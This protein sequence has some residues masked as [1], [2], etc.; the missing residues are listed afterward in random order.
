MSMHDHPTSHSRAERLAFAGLDSGRRAALACQLPRLERAI[1]AA[2][3]RFY[4]HMASYPAIHAQL[5]GDG[6]IGRLKSLQAAHWRQLL[7]ARFDAA[8]FARAQAIG[9]AH[10]R[11]GL[12]PADYIAGY[13][14]VLADLAADL[15]AQLRWRPGRM[16]AAVSA[17]IEAALFDMALSLG[18][19]IEGGRAQ[20]EKELKALADQLE[21]QV[22]AGVHAV[23]EDSG[24]ARRDA[25]EMQKATERAGQRSATVAAA[26]EEASAN[27]DTVA[28][29]AQEFA[30]SA[31]EIERQASMSKEVATRA[32]TGAQGA[33]EVMRGL[34]GRAEE[35]GAIVEV[36]S[37]IAAQ[38]NLL[39]LNATIEAARAGD[40]GKG[41]A[42]VAG[43]VKNL[44]AQ[45]ARA[46]TQISEQIATVQDAAGDA[47][48]A[49]ESISGI[50][51]ELEAVADSINGAA[52]QQRAAS[53]EISGNVQE[54][55]SGNRE[56]ASNIQAV[57]QE[58][59]AVTELA[60]LVQAAS[61]RTNKSIEALGGRVRELLIKLRNHN[62]AN[63]RQSPRL[64]ADH[65]VTV[66]IVAETG[67]YPPGCSISPRAGR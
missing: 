53:D 43:E 49:I 52:D 28:A 65:A 56:V 37:D 36:I 42:V 26:S 40:A 31:R 13:G 34:A 59:Q 30:A 38:T 35:I 4:A 2:L 51:A 54:A 23:A 7:G 41:F 17:L 19:Y 18:V 55:A 47:V 1:P 46:T 32:V 61:D 29:A 58:T 27:V 16:R 14:F 5:S 22:S 50:I 67:V 12:D 44:A 64:P 11:I 48:A 45:T 60:H 62:A 8:Y 21:E 15:A 6:R 57:A 66:E 33:G 63:R 39:A 25:V 10:H 3:D 20:L 24:K 9:Q